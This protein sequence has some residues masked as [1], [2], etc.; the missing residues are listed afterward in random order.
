METMFTVQPKKENCEKR[1]AGTVNP[2]ALNPYS[3]EFQLNP[4]EIYQQMQ[5]EFPIY[6][7]R[8]TVGTE[9]MVTRFEDIKKILNNPDFIVENL[10]ARIPPHNELMQA[11][12]KHIEHLK[13]S[14]SPWLFSLDPPKHTQLRQLVSRDFT[15]RA[16]QEIEPYIEFLVN[17]KFESLGNGEFDLIEHLAK[18]LPLLVSAK[19]LGLSINDLPAYLRCAESL[20]KIFEQPLTYRDIGE[21]SKSALFFSERIDQELSSRRLGVPKDDF[22]GKLDKSLL[23]ENEF[24]SFCVMLFAV[25]QETTENYIGNSIAALLHDT[26][27][28][29]LLR[30]N[31]DLIDNAIC[32]LARFDSAVQ[33]ISRVAN[34]SIT[35]HDV[36]IAEGDRVYLCLGAANRDP[37]QYTNPNKLDINRDSKGN[38]PFGSGIHFCLGSVLAKLQLKYVLK[39]II[40]LPKLTRNTSKPVLRRKT[41]VIR[42]YHH[43]PLI[44]Q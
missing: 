17:S 3:K 42:G 16:L 39:K 8:A 41:V 24:K 43:L 9:W 7:Y 32:E 11:E 15:S 44:I 31:P 23:N 25:G 4:Y 14:L 26:T 37:R 1:A 28:Y 20:F 10:P 30:N 12:K 29:E 22:L 40:E 38:F 2:L 6:R 21:M 13:Q 19:L 34:A 35:M 5:D 18:P 36:N 27:Q 33:I